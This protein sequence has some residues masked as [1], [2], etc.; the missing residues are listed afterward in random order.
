MVTHLEIHS[1]WRNLLDIEY[2]CFLALPSLHPGFGQYILYPLKERPV[3]LSHHC[4][5]SAIPTV[6]NG[7]N[8]TRDFAASAATMEAHYATLDVSKA[9]AAAGVRVL[10]DE[11]FFAE[12]GK[13]YL[14]LGFLLHFC[15]HQGK[16]TT[17]WSCFLIGSENVWGRYER[18]SVWVRMGWI[19]LECLECFIGMFTKVLLSS[20][21][22]H[23]K[24]GLRT[25]QVFVGWISGLNDTPSGVSRP[26]R[27]GV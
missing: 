1:L 4:S 18:V 11:K 6:I 12:V 27:P 21:V 13:S 15:R 9:L 26:F 23:W 14:I 22:L 8:H 3:A 25:C 7:G 16:L 20:Y 5:A 19:Y 24:Y 17:I 2:L 10:T